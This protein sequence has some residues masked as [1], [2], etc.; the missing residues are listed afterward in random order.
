MKTYAAIGRKLVNIILFQ[1]A[2]FAAV[3]G[4]AK[5][6]DWYG[7]LAVLL[8]LS[9]HFMLIH[10]RTSEMALLLVAGI[11]GF[12]FD[13]AMSA[14]GVVTPRGHI[15]PHPFSQPWMISLWLLFAAT[16]NVSLEWLKKSYLLATIFGAVGGTFAYYSGARLGATTA[17]PD[18]HGIIILAL[19][20][21]I[22]NP[23]LI[24]FAVRSQKK[25]TPEPQLEKSSTHTG[26]RTA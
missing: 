17:L 25:G 11:F 10:N 7:P 3:L 24:W 23:I 9:I 8:V 20:W 6:N 22:M 26:G 13:T 5:G 4:A 21:G 12:C 14:A 19:G 18:F 15:M 16:L 1:V 2:W